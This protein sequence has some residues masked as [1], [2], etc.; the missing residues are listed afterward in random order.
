MRRRQRL[1]TLVIYLNSLT[2]LKLG[3]VEHHISLNR[4]HFHQ[5]NNTNTLQTHKQHNGR[6][7]RAC[8]F[9]ELS[10][11]DVTRPSV[12]VYIYML[13]RSWCRLLISLWGIFNQ[14]SET[15]CSIYIVVAL[16]A[17]VDTT[18]QFS[19]FNKSWR[20]LRRSSTPHKK[21]PSRPFYP[22]L[23]PSPFFQN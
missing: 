9:A 22:T 17:E 7:N 5:I 18:M 11:D 13:C 4:K 15:T 20:C 19:D 14:L 2:E 10:E 6:E 12:Y 21:T 3:R 23:T 8:S 1:P 16:Y